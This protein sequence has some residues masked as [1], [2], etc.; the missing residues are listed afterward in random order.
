[1]PTAMFEYAEPTQEWRIER[2]SGASESSL[3]PALPFQHTQAALS[4]MKSEVARL[5]KELHD[6][7]AA[8]LR[9]AASQRTNDLT[10]PAPHFPIA[11]AGAQK[12]PVVDAA[13]VVVAS[14]KRTVGALEA[15]MK[16][17]LAALEQEQVR[18]SLDDLDLEA[19]K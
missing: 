11:P 4:A 14:T 5:E 1:M 7:Q 8:E 10:Q 9:S 18:V 19:D 13:T 15:E 2:D 17:K 3:P 16:R 12:P 6:K